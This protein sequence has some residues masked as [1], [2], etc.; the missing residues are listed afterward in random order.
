MSFCMHTYNPPTHTHAHITLPMHTSPLH[1]SPHSC[2]PHTCT[3]HLTMHTSLMHTSSMHTSPMHTSP[4]HT[5]PMHTS[6]CTPH[7]HTHTHSQL[8][9]EWGE[10][11]VDYGEG[12]SN[13][14]AACNM[15]W[16]RLSAQDLYSKKNILTWEV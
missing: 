7:P 1:T 10:V 15:D 2:T 8:E 11:K 5:S 16:D 3:H 14:L 9:H 13:R 6:P 12:T 4:M